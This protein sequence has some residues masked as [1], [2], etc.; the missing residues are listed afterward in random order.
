MTGVPTVAGW[1]HEVG[2]R[3]REAYVSRVR[4]ADE[5]YRGTPARR[6]ALLRDHDVR[7]VWVGEAERARYGSVSFAGI[8]GVDPVVETE[9]VTL[10]AVDQSGLGVAPQAAPRGETTV[11]ASASTAVVSS[12]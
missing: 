1:H 7:Y 9:S 12:Q 3:G 10:Y 6:V 11:R 8:A 2:Y 4:A 5:M